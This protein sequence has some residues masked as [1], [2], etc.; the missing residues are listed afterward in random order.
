MI[1][2]KGKYWLIGNCLVIGT[3]LLAIALIAE[4]HTVEVDNTTPASQI[5]T[6][7][8]GL[9]KLLLAEAIFH[10]E[11]GFG[12]VYVKEFADEVGVT[13][14][15]KRQCSP[16]QFYYV[17]YGDG[18]W[19]YIVADEKE[20][21]QEILIEKDFPTIEQTKACIAE[22]ESLGVDVNLTENLTYSL[23]EN[24]RTCGSSKGYW[25]RLFTLQDGVLVMED[26]FALSDNPVNYHF[27]TDEEWRDECEKWN[28]FAILPIDKQDGGTVLREPS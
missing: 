8:H 1:Y 20:Q 26:P 14:E 12:D 17:I 28:G 22:L 9:K 16:N 19:G 3:V 18:Y 27:F 25:H 10:V 23:H 5:I 7:D 2:V 6:V 4:T 13:L 15:C 24:W 21:I 11:D